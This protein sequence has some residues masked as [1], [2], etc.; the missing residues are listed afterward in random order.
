MR[1]TLD[2]E[3]QTLLGVDQHIDGSDT[4]DKPKRTGNPLMKG[5]EAG[6]LETPYPLDFYNGMMSDEFCFEKTSKL[7]L[8]PLNLKTEKQAIDF[9]KR[10]FKWNSQAEERRIDG[11]VRDILARAGEDPKVLERLKDSLADD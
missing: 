2:G 6:M 3:Q 10:V 4:A 9:L 1:A 5:L 7:I 11:I 8:E